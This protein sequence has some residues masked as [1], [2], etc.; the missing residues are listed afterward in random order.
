[1]T[2]LRLRQRRRTRPHESGSLTALCPRPPGMKQP[3][4]G[5][6]TA[7]GVI[8]VREVALRARAQCDF[9]IAW[10]RTRILRIM[11][12][13]PS[14]AGWL[15]LGASPGLCRACRHAKLTETSRGTAYVRCTRAAWDRA[16]ARYPRLP[17]TQCTG[18]D[19]VSAE[20]TAPGS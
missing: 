13:L 3:S 5:M 17:V 9:C 15:K 12:D 1:M 16:L 10:V 11:P 2:L 4:T 14:G 20:S 8:L 7:A 18:F 6:P 19:C